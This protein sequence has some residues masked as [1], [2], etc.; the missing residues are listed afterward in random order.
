VRCPPVGSG[1][2]PV[3]NLVLYVPINK[4]LTIIRSVSNLINP[5]YSI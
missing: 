3:F 4:T 1:T 5:E 2:A